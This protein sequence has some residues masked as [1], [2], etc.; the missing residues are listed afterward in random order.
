VA[1]LVLGRVGA[2]GL[3]HPDVDLT[4]WGAVEYGVSRLH[5]AIEIR[6]EAVFLTDLGSTNGTYLNGLQL[7]AGEHRVVCSGD[8]IYFGNLL[9]HLYFRSLAQIG[10]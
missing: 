3:R 5:A 8:A 1:R 9:T 10:D 2:S 4:A 7:P 6:E